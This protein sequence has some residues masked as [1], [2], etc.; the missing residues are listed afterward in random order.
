MVIFV[1][2]LVWALN[3]NFKYRIFHFSFLENFTVLFILQF[4]LFT[5]SLHERSSDFLIYILSST[6]F[7]STVL[8]FS[9]FLLVG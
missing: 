4:I 6:L 1:Y 7:L 2:K 8:L 9:D 5:F 3:G